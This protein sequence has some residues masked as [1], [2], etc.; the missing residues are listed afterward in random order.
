MHLGLPP[1]PPSQSLAEA[2]LYRLLHVG[3]PGDLAFY[4]RACESSKGRRVLECGSGFGRLSFHL[5]DLGYLV[6]GIESDHDKYTASME[7]RAKRSQYPAPPDFMLADF[8]ALVLPQRFDRVLIPYN[9]LWALGGRNGIRQALLRAHQHLREEGELWFDVYPL[10]DFHR[11][12]LEGELDDDE[13]PSELVLETTHEGAA[14]Q[15]FETTSIFIEDQSLLV[16]YSAYERTGHEALP[17]NSPEIGGLTIRHDYL[18]LDQIWELLEE[19]GFSIAGLFGNFDGAPE[20]DPPAHIIVCATK[21]PLE[22]AETS[23]HKEREQLW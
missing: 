12:I 17:A 1:H 6:L 21:V 7:A 9:T 15:V 3:N 13:A 18:L 22:P 14:I 8:R 2:E 5:A 16:R 19:I 23:H 10:D 4:A 11:A 20:E